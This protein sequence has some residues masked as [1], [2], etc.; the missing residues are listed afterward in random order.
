MERDLEY[1]T[2]NIA[3]DEQ[4]KDGAIKCKNYELCESVLPS[5][6][7][8]CKGCYLCT[9]CDMMFG[10]VLTKTEPSECPLCLE[11]VGGLMLPK[12]EHSICLKCFDRCYYGN[13]SVE[14]VTF[15]YPEIE[16]AYFEDPENKKWKIRYPLIVLYNKAVN[17]WCDRNEREYEREEYLRKCPLCRK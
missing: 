17:E 6:W 16:D 10:K 1:E 11:V 9:N 15:P 5:W 12:C 13:K 4:Y 8:E 7:F 3:C 2:Q 14:Q